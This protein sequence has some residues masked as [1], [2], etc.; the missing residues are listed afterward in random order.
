MSAPRVSVVVPVLDAGPDLARAL[1]SVAAQRPAAAVETIVVDDGSTEP[2]TLA[3]LDAAARR[4]GVTVHRTPNRGP[5]AAR[6]TAIAAARGDYVLPLDADDWLHPAFLARTVPILD[7]EPEVG[8]VHTWVGLVGGHHG[9]WRTGRFGLPELLARCTVHVCSLYRRALWTDVGGYDESFRDGAE[10]WDFW[11]AAAGRG[12]TA[13]AVPEVLAYYQRSA[14][15]RERRARAPGTSGRLVRA[16]VQKHR[17]LYEAHLEDAL[18]AMYEEVT[19]TAL[20]LER[21]YDH[22][23][24]RAAVR[25]RGWFGRRQR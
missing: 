14:G 10:D 17:A 23:A 7:A 8:I 5:A 16:L 2:R 9:V 21:V 24:V 4:P 15:S 1:D 22:A 19:A 3:L 12:W 13:R 6:N 11:L 18:G 20:A 25:V